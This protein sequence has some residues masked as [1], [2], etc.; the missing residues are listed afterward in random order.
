M[1][2]L[3]V[4]VGED[5]HIRD[6]RSA[7]IGDASADLE[8]GSGRDQND[9]GLVD[10]V[11]DK[12]TALNLRCNQT[13]GGDFILIVEKNI[14]KPTHETQGKVAICSGCRRRLIPLTPQVGPDLDSGNGII[15]AVHQAATENRGRRRRSKVDR[16]GGWRTDEE[17]IGSRRYQIQGSE[18][19]RITA[20][21]PRIVVGRRQQAVG[22]VRVSESMTSP[23][24]SR[25]DL[26]LHGC[27]RNRG[28]KLVQ[29]RSKGHCFPAR[30]CDEPAA[31]GERSE[32][33][34]ALVVVGR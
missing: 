1:E 6:W 19:I 16:I 30:Q 9:I 29:N 33:D 4:I 10:P 18:G 5:L 15:G 13:S 3:G 11:G 25:L 17:G 34:H 28:T 12:E 23:L 31:R 14:P 26:T 20:E 7:R 2:V 21:T 32:I 22:A 8:R 27:E 24:C